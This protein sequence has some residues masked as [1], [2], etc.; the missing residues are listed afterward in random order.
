MSTNPLDRGEDE[1]KG[2]PHP[3]FPF[4]ALGFRCNPFRAVTDEEWAELAV[5]PESLEAA[6]AAGAVHLQ[7][8]GQKG[9][10][11]TTALLAL[12]AR[13]KR[14]GK[15]ATYE[16]L[17]IGQTR[18]KTALASFADLDVFLLDEVDRLSGAERKRLCAALS[19]EGDGLRA[20]ISSHEDLSPLFTRYRLPLTTLHFNSATLAH[21]ETVIRRRL[22]YFAL[23]PSQTPGLTLST[24]AIAYL[25]QT[26]GGDLRAVELLLY[27]VFQGV[28][29]RGEIGIAYFVSR[30]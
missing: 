18:F 12:T 26:Y 5:L 19:R 27:E 21:L 16:H 17:E 13:F 24:E 11:K 7:I 2:C 4:H 6:L 23:D 30:E 8:L 15:Q 9:Y 28:K 22:A 1:G 20:V 29:E 14:E 25:Q 10:G 3:Y